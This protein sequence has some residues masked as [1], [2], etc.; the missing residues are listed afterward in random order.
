MTPAEERH[1][2][3][4]AKL[5]AEIA[6][7]IAERKEI[8]AR[9]NLP[10]YRRPRFIQAIVAGVVALP[11]IW[12]Y[13]EEVALPSLNATRLEQ[14]IETLRIRRDLNLTIDT[15][16]SDLADAKS[17]NQETVVA[18]STAREEIEQLRQQLAA[19]SEESRQLASQQPDVGRQQQLNEAADQAQAVVDRL[20]TTVLPQIEQQQSTAEE[21]I[22]QLEAQSQQLNQ[23]AEILN[24]SPAPGELNENA[25]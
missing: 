18:L 7:A 19:V 20:D 17:Q 6:K 2:F 8:E 4:I 15:L 16:R 10:W 5:R 1:Q 3:E 25:L 23:D 24:E 9:L 12:F 14:Q 11:V 22:D 13:F 21:R